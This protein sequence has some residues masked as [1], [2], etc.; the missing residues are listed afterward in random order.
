MRG[1]IVVRGARV[2]NL[3][4]IDLEIPR[5]RLVVVTGVSGSGKSSLAF[6]TLYA[7]GQRRYIESLSADT[8]QLLQQL[9]KPDVDS[10]EGLSPALA[11]QQRLT[12]F[13]TRSTVGTVSEIYDFLRLLFARVG[14]AVCIQCSKPISVQATEQIVDQLT[15]LPA[16]T[17]VVLLAPV[18]AA[19]K[20]VERKLL[21]ELAAQGFTRVRIDGEFHEISQEMRLQSHDLRQIDVVIDRLVIRAGVEKRLAD[22]LEIA[23]RVGDQFI[24]AQLQSEPAEH[25]KPKEVRFSRRYACAECGSSFPEVTP[26]LFSFNSPL[27]ACPACGG[28]GARRKAQRQDGAL[29]LDDLPCGACNGLRLKSESLSVTL[30]AKNI[31]QLAALPI[32]QAILFFGDLNLADKHKVVGRSIIGEILGRLRIL[33]QLGLDYLTLDRPLPTLSAGEAQRVRLATQMGS[34]LAGVLYILDEPSLGLHQKDNAR[35]LNLLKTLRDAGNSVLV[36]EHDPETILSADHVIDMGPGAGLKGGE[37]VAH[38]TAAELM[39]NERSLTGLYLSG[40]KRVSRPRRRRSGSG[41]CV[42][43]QRAQRNNLRDLTVEIPLGAMTCVTGVSGSGKTT[44]VSDILYEQVARGLRSGRTQ[45]QREGSVVGW[46]RFDRV[47][48]VDQSPIGKTPRANPA[49][50]TGIQDH[51]RELFAQLPEARVRGYKADRFSFNS[52]AGQCATCGGDG[53]VRVEMYFLPDVFSICDVCK[54]QRYN[55]ETLEVKYKGRSIAEVLQITVTEALGLFGNIPAVAGRLQTLASVGLGY[56][57]LGQPSHTLS[58]GEAQRLKLARELARRSTGR[59]LY[60]LDEP[61][62]GLHFADVA[63]LLDLLH[64][65]TDAGNTL[66]IIEHNLDVIKNADYVIDLGPGAGPDGGAIV[67]RGTPEDVAAVSHSHTGRY[68]ARALAES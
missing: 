67:A 37:V 56:L 2:H 54:G 60:V 33:A 49:T 5:E 38:G 59:S 32:N 40:Q 55:R 31:A 68:L 11:V 57:Q 62:A 17:R 58:G 44:L 6:D 34:R 21:P 16:G 1:E 10:I 53:L 4:N 52:R 29:S 15:A 28:S 7:E 18:A 8:R 45:S 3:K 27:G 14:E 50:Y 42:I 12:N 20:I 41:E 61:T 26:G 9:D 25:A 22:S 64:R 23:A 30:A 43:I 24:K 63:Q 39:V 19:G 66:V 65:L 13:G 35:L 51:L 36:V 46:Q 47:V 48:R